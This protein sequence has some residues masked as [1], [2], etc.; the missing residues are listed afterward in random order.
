MAER[1]VEDESE[2]DTFYGLFKSLKEDL[3][4]GRCRYEFIE[5]FLRSIPGNTGKYLRYIILKRFFKSIGKNVVIC[6]G[7][8][9]RYPSRIEIGDNVSI[10]FGCIFQGGGGISIGDNT[11][12]GPGVK[13][14]SMNH[15]FK[16]LDRTINAQGFEGRPVVIGSDCWI[17][18]NTF[19][20]P[21][22]FIPNGTVIFP[23]SV[24]SRIKIPEYS[25][26]TGNPAKVV[27]PR[28]RIGAFMGWRIDE[29]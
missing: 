13:A 9:F 26:L 27:G 15:M 8:R 10:S 4:V 22:S 19:I 14:W 12:F 11:L 2:P 28:N 21:G 17:G 23:C 1:W 25:V 6:P 3:F 16:Q 29:K 20:K 24:V 5:T 18:S 7:V